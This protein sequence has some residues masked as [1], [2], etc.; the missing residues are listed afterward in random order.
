MRS[1]KHSVEVAILVL[2]A[3]SAGCSR[4][5]P[6]QAK[7]D[8]GPIAIQVAPVVVKQVRRVVESVGTLYPY[9]ETVVSA[10]IDGRVDKVEVD[11]GDPVTM[12]QVMVHISDE[13]QRYLLTQNE[14]QL[15]QSLGRLGLKD[16]NDKVKDIRDTP[17]PR[18]AQADLTD[19]EQHYQRARKMF[20]QGIAAQAD[21]DQ[22][23]ARYKAAQAAYDSI[24][25]QTRNLVSEVERTKAVLD[26]QR[27]KLRDTSVRAPLNGFVKEKQVTVGQYVRVN[28]PLMTLVKTDPIRLRIEIPERMAPW[29]KNGQT[30][31]V[32]ME[33]FPDKTFEG[34][35]WRISPTVDQS[36]RTFIAEALIPNASGALKPGSYARARVPTGK[37][38]RVRLV[39]AKAVNYV[40]G[41]N[42]VYV[43]N[44]G[45]VEARE[46]KVGDRFDQDV[47][48]LDGIQDGEQVAITKINLL[49]TG[50]KVRIAE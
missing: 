44:A 43:V 10:E 22:A 41:A 27:K 31:D 26:M 19:A 14:S 35:I 37:T 15:R 38:D 25:N 5:Q 50:S 3:L 39:P 40:F 33:A 20:E 48:I 46:V 42:K 30:V 24:L 23:Q 12:G 28:T 1:H 17:D 36:K 13:E 32:S 16:E 29:I 45:K 21:L 34:R 7:Q 18:R 9:D 8:S 11:L 49:D 4:Q 2:M 47:E 6:V